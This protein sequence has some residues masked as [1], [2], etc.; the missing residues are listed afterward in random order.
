MERPTLRKK[1]K[2]DGQ[3]YYKLSGFN[4]ELDINIYHDGI[5]IFFMKENDNPEV[6]RMLKYMTPEEIRNMPTP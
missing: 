5:S 3:V 1:R 6:L 4:G 2:K